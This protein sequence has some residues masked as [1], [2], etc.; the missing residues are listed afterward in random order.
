MPSDQLAKR[1]LIKKTKKLTQAKMIM[2]KK[3]ALN[4][5]FINC[6]NNCFITLKGHKPNFLNNPKASRLNTA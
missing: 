3:T 5:K 2:E 1:F 4:R 6:K